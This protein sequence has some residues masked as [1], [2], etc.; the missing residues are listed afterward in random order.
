LLLFAPQTAIF[1]K[2]LQYISVIDGKS[3]WQVYTIYLI[4]LWH[5]IKIYFRN[6]LQLR[7]K[8][9]FV[10]PILLLFA[11]KNSLFVTKCALFFWQSMITQN[12]NFTY[13]MWSFSHTKQ[14][15]LA[16]RAFLCVQF[17]CFLLKNWPLFD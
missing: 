5:K 15:S 3:T 1:W 14:K 8:S 10:Y 7:L 4:L 11:P 9:S 16:A 17:P 12:G 6:S 13:F 2:N